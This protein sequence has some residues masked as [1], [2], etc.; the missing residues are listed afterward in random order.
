MSVWYELTITMRNVVEINAN[1]NTSVIWPGKV[2]DLFGKS[3]RAWLILY[4]VVRVVRS[5]KCAHLCTHASIHFFGTKN[6]QLGLDAI[7]QSAGA[8]MQ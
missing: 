6:M 8:V 5:H 3:A 4:V 1:I 2:L 7:A